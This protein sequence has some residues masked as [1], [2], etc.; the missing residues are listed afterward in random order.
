MALFGKNKS[1]EEL[2]AD[3]DSSR[4]SIETEKLNVS[5]TSLEKSAESIE[6]LVGLEKVVTDISTFV[7]T[8]KEKG[9][10]INAPDFHGFEYNDG[11]ITN[12]GVR[13]YP[14]QLLA[15]DYDEEQGKKLAEEYN[16]KL[17]NDAKNEQLISIDENGNL[18]F[19]KDFKD[20]DLLRK[21]Y[22]N[23]MKSLADSLEEQAEKANALVKEAKHIEVS[24]SKQVKEKLDELTKANKQELEQARKKTKEPLSQ[25]FVDGVKAG[26]S[27][28]AK[29]IGASAVL[30]VG[31]AIAG[32]SGIAVAAGVVGVAT[33]GKVLGEKAKDLAGRTKDLA[34]NL[35]SYAK[36]SFLELSEYREGKAAA[37][38]TFRDLD[39][40]EIDIGKMQYVLLKEK[41]IEKGGDEDRSLTAMRRD[42]QSAKKEIVD[43]GWSKPTFMAVKEKVRHARDIWRETSGKIFGKIKD[44]FRDVKD[45]LVKPIGKVLDDYA[46][47]KAPNAADKVKSGISLATKRVKTLT[48]IM[49]EHLMPK[50]VDA[51][52]GQ[53]YSYSVAP[54]ANSCKDLDSIRDDI[55]KVIDRAHSLGIRNIEN[56]LVETYEKNEFADKDKKDIEH[57]DK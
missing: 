22:Q 34:I 35:G 27:V 42:L 17:S 51:T 37:K 29:V 8:A 12:E 10:D 2:L 45:N 43:R 15:G 11:T 19:P 28:S 1:N 16:K 46:V 55:D 25:K 48:N 54:F 13:V 33:V 31:G 56:N 38:E 26:A 52:T 30:G 14:Y 21:D 53:A 32:T 36:K 44:A 47:S 18:N 49:T 20:F 41:V 3:Y 7:Q 50:C 5:L 57:D 9:I 40:W 39:K 4:R 6:K 24:F 23:V